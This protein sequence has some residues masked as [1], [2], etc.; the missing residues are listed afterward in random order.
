MINV[1][2]FGWLHQRTILTHSHSF[3]EVTKSP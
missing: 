3:Y 1:A 2:R